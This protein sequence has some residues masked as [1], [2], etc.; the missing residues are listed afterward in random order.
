MRI[1]TK[2]KFNIISVFITLL[3]LLSCEDF[4]PE[5]YQELEKAPVSELDANAYYY[6]T[7]NLVD[8][9]SD[10]ALYH[11]ANPY[12]INTLVSD[13]WADS[14]DSIIIAGNF[15]SLK[16]KL[17]T[18]YTDTTVL[19]NHSKDSEDSYV[20]FNSGESGYLY[21]FTTWDLTALNLNANISIDFYNSNGEKAN[22]LPSTISLETIEKYACVVVDTTGGAT[23]RHPICKIRNKDKYEIN[24]KSYLI[25]LHVS[26][27]GLGNNFRLVML[28]GE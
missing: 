18:V 7:R 17:D 2:E 16:V 3:I 5:Q 15:D 4:L 19:I 1:L 13:A 25:H 26:D 9:L 14:S 10:K 20:F 6:L 23:N 24:Q 12:I 21:C 11:S 27:P 8:T 22:L 28:Y